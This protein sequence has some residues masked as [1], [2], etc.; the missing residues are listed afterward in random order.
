MSD[1]KPGKIKNKT[2]NK[3]ITIGGKTFNDLLKD[4][5]NDKHF[6]PSELQKAL[7]TLKDVEKVTA[8]PTKPLVKP[9]VKS[10]KPIV[11]PIKK[12]KFKFNEKTKD[13]I[14]Q[15]VEKM[16]KEE[17]KNKIKANQKQINKFCKSNQMLDIPIV[18]KS[19]E[20]TFTYKSLDS[21]QSLKDL[22]NCTDTKKM[23]KTKVYDYRILH[24]YD[25]SLDAVDVENK[26]LRFSE[27]NIDYEW[28]KKGNEYISSLSHKDVLTLKSYTYKGDEIANSHVMGTWLDD[29]GNYPSWY[30][31]SHQQEV[32]SEKKDYESKYYYPLFY[33]IYDLI[34]SKYMKTPEKVIDKSYKPVYDIWTKLIKMISAKKSTMFDIYKLVLDMVSLRNGQKGTLN[35]EFG[36]E[37]MN[38]YVKDLERIIKNSPKIEKKMIVYRGVNNDYFMEDRKL[39]VYFKNKNFLST[40]LNPAVAL[41]FSFEVNPDYNPDNSE[42]CCISE[43]TLL[44]GTRCIWISGMSEYPAENEVLLNNG[45]TYLIRSNKVEYIVDPI[46]APLKKTEQ[47]INDV[48][49]DVIN[50]V[51]T[52]VI[53]KKTTISSIVAL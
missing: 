46:N 1:C 50:D 14:K 6:N 10:T 19:L 44:P 3:C 20:Y 49:E 7:K 23:F 43:I 22:L 17:I 33:Q 53:P 27:N 9:M 11:K 29:D 48:E 36:I 30:F 15:Y 12:T 35:N 32:D 37:A 31:K 38:M 26:Q 5:K 42:S 8:K 39:N 47:E 51:C 13:K 25:Y 21:K 18:K 24:T 45:T 4:N 40:S 2:T 28:F 16:K 52:H 34:K 41:H